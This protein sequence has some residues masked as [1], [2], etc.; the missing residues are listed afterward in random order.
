MQLHEPQTEHET[1]T[2]EAY[3]P[4]IASTERAAREGQRRFRLLARTEILPIVA[5]AALV[6]TFVLGE[7]RLWTTENENWHFLRIVLPILLSIAFAA[8]IANRTRDYHGQWFDAR[9]MTETV[10]SLTWRYIT[11][12]MPFEGGPHDL[13]IDREFEYTIHDTGGHYPGTAELV[14]SSSPSSEQITPAMRRH[15]ERPLE[16]RRQLYLGARV[17]DQIAW[18]TQRAERSREMSARWFWGAVIVQTLL[19]A[20]T[21]IAVWSLT[22]AVLIGFFATVSSSTAALARVHRHDESRRRYARAAE[23]LRYLREGV[24]GAEGEDAFSDSVDAAEQAIS[25]EHGVWLARR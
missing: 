25:R 7:D 13:N 20:A 8:K 1:W 23:E 3:P 17:D 5:V 2:D 22:L 6:V 11:R 18:Y 14:E 15:R 4:L 19:L 12:A 24:A 16:E 21:I 9:A 10:K